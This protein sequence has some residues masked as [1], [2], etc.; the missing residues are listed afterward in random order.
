MSYYKPT[1]KHLGLRYI[2]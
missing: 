1:I 2:I